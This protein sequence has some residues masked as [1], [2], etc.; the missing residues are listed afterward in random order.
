MVSKTMASISTPGPALSLSHQCAGRVS[1][2][3]GPL[4]RTLALMY[5]HPWSS[6]KL[7]PLGRAGGGACA[8]STDP[9]LEP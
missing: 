6:P 2:Q 1:L 7:E 3:Y 9:W 8:C 5:L 4:A